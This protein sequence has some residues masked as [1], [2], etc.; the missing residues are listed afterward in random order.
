MSIRRD[1]NALPRADLGEVIGEFNPSAEGFIAREVLPGRETRERAAEI[2]V[3]KRENASRV[4]VDHANGAA[5]NR[6][7]MATGNVPYA[8]VE[9][10]LEGPV[11]SEDIALAMSEYDAEAEVTLDVHRKLL[12]ER[13]IR[14]KE[15]VLNTSTWTGAAL[16][17]DNSGSP[18]ATTSTDI[19]AQ[20]NAAKEKV[21]INTGYVPNTLV[22]GQVPMNHLLVNDDIISRFPGSPIISEAMIRAQLAAIFGLENLVVGK[23]VY[24]S[25]NQGQDYVGA[26]IWGEQFVQVCKLSMGSLRSGGLG[27]TMIWSAMDSIGESPVETYPEEQTDSTIIRDREYSQE[28]IF[29]EF[30]A[31]MMKIKA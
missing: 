3:I 2:T 29:D 4:N 23:Q 20:V 27:R 14:V 19:I 30:F 22:M 24:N 7:T 21:R 8:A 16:Y 12:V 13:E 5:F 17:T 26:D 9:H 15:L 28:L 11:T 31:H 10:G 6:I 1:S 18:W 25:A